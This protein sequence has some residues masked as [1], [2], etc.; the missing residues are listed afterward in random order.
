M[1]F[2]EQIK[3]TI[4]FFTH[5]AI[6]WSKLSS[7]I[8]GIYC[9]ATATIIIFTLSFK[10]HSAPVLPAWVYRALSKRF[11]FRTRIYNILML[12]HMYTTLNIL[13]LLRV[14]APGRKWHIRAFPVVQQTRSLEH[15]ALVVHSSPEIASS[16]GNADG[17]GHAKSKINN[18]L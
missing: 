14:D 13:L 15:S 10:K 8:F 6:S 5:T 17:T 12:I 11:R 18:I 9:I 2:S 4:N 16:K 3:R 7:I 1:K